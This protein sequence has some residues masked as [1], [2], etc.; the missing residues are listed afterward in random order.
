MHEYGL[1]FTQLPHYSPEMIKDMRSRMSLFVDGLGRAS[2]KEGRAAML[3]GDMDILRL[4][5]YVQ[6]VK[7][8]KLNDKEEY[9]SKKAKIGNDFGQHK[10]D[11]DWLQF[12]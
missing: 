9:K 10:C 1:K 11:L 4:M 5:V 6:K 2:R 7:E 3:I 12:Y 8:E